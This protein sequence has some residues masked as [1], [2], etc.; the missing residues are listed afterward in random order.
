[1][2]EFWEQRYA[3]E[4]LAYGAEA[5]AF[6]AGQRPRLRPGMQTLA[7]GDGQGRNGVWLARQGLQVL[8]VDYSQ[9]GLER[10]RQLASSHGVTLDT[11]CVDLFT[12]QWPRDCYDLIVVIFVH[13]PPDQRQRLHQLMLQALKPG[14]LLI[15][16]GFTPEQLQYKSGGPP[17][18]ELLYDR[19]MLAEDFRDAEIELLE[20]TLTELDE[21]PYHQG[22]AAVVRLLARR[23]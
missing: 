21:G 6:L 4:S 7:V 10:A 14:G 8:S 13:F 16:E 20:E 2:R 11:L 15:L 9:T 12:W 23:R 1:M 18:R 5:N 22:T 19:A 17:V 3:E